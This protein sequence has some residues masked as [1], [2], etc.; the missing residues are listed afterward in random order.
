L[1]TFAE[2]SIQLLKTTRGCDASD[3]GSSC[4]ENEKRKMPIGLKAQDGIIREQ[5]LRKKVG[6]HR[7][8][9]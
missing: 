5:K 2:N 1:N 4:E 6:D 9:R 8:Q 3:G 7:S